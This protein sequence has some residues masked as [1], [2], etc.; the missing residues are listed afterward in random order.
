MHVGSGSKPRFVDSNVF[1]YVLLK[2]PVYGSRAL[3]ILLRFEA[4]EERGLTSTLVVSQV[5]AHLARRRAERAIDRFLVYLANVP[6]RVVETSF[7]DFQEAVRLRRR[8]NL[9]WRL[10]DD[11]VIAAQMKRLGV[12]EIYTNDR[13]FDRIPLVEKIF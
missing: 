5:L 12:R 11:L 7:E 6:I 1:V 9:S 8:L 10:W 2:D 4:G 3:D 13:D